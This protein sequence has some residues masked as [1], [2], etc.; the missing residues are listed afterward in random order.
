MT[1]RDMNANSTS[2]ANAATATTRRPMW[3]RILKVSA[4]TLMAIVLYAFGM[5]AA[6]LGLL[7]PERLTPLLEH[8]A[9]NTLRADVTLGHAQ[10]SIRGSFP[11]LGIEM[12]D[13]TVVSRDIKT[14][15]AADREMLPEWADTL[16]TVKSFEGSIKL[17][18]LL[19]GDI[20]IDSVIIDRPQANIVIVDDETNNYDIFPPSEEEDT[21]A[22]NIADLPKITLT[23][24][25]LTNPGPVRF[26]SDG[27]MA[28]ASFSAISLSGKD[29]PLYR[30]DF[31][32]DIDCP[33]ISEIFGIED[34]GFG[35]NGNIRWD[36]AKPEEIALEGFAFKMSLIQGNIDTGVNIGDSARINDLRLH[37]DPL[38]VGELLAAV[39]ED[40]AEFYGIPVGI[41]T[42]ARISIDAKLLK[43]FSLGAD[44]DALPTMD[45]DVFVADSYLKWQQVDFRHLSADMS[46]H[47]DGNDLNASVLTIRQLNI[48]GPATNLHLTGIVTEMLGDPLFDGKVNGVSH[49]GALPPQLKRLLGGASISGD[50]TANAR[51][52]GRPS[53]LS[54]GGFQRLLV[55]GDIG[56]RK[57]RWESDTVNYIY[58]DRALFRFGTQETFRRA[59]VTST[60]LLTAN[61]TADSVYMSTPEARMHLTAL[62]MGIGTRNSH[63]H[64]CDHD[65]QP[66]GGGLSF[67]RY[68]MFSVADSSRV[69]LR[70]VKGYA[71]AKAYEGDEHRPHL[72]FDLEMKRFSAGDRSTRAVLR[73]AKTH[74][75]AILRPETDR[76]R[77]IRAIGDS[78]HRADPTLD[79]DSVYEMASAEYRRRRGRPRRAAAKED[80]G[81]EAID[82]GTTTAMRR[83]L[84][85]WDI[86]GTIAGKRAR[87]YTPYFP[88]RNNL[89]DIDIAF[90]NDSLNINHIR[91]IV[92][93]S[94]F[95]I[96][97][98]V[99]NIKKALT[100]RRKK[101]PLGIHLDVSSDTIDVNQLAQAI[102]T[103]AAYS[104][105]AAAGN[106]IN[107]GDSDN[108]IDLDCAIQQQVATE[109]DT[110]VPIL[111]PTNIDAN[112]HIDADNVRYADLM[113]H[114]LHGHA[115]IYNGALNLHELNATSDVGDINLSALYMG[116]RVDELS[117]GFGMQLSRFN[118]SNF[119]SLVPA[120]DSIMPVLRNFSG[121]IDAEIAATTPISPSMDFVLPDFKAAVKLDGKQLV[122]IDPDTFKMLSKWLF[123]KNKKRNIID[124]M[125]I[126]MMV[127]NNQL[128]IFP[129]IFDIDRYRLGIQGYNDFALNF[130]YHVAV[131]KSPLPF[132]FG[133]NIS[134]NPDKMKIRL[135]RARLKPDDALAVNLVDTTRI[136]LLRQISNVFRRGIREGD[137]ARLRLG[138]LHN[139]G[140]SPADEI[141]ANDTLSAADSAAFIREGLIEAPEPVATPESNKSK[142]T[143]NK[144]NK[145]DK[146][147]KRNNP[148]ARDIKDDEK[149]EEEKI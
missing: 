69:R 4:W 112:I 40:M 104:S 62:K 93:S 25:A 63:S 123:F 41:N 24:F 14:L 35:L 56:L 78:I 101:Q 149:S 65:I 131:L 140:A 121:I 76:T 81:T 91:Y 102:F 44:G 1:F 84:R 26:Y 48:A 99:S 88:L 79:R 144:K 142:V 16:L 55:K 110:V 10:L 135:G 47:L 115:M 13:L 120:I 127:E 8:V 37:L 138:S 31:D 60:G 145:S 124:Q 95:T 9:N 86:S 49:L 132:K 80:E 146:R 27:A 103:G 42:N 22:F 23:R 128:Q 20:T 38:P 11:Y 89:R 136:N 114:G 90:N 29:K 82:F 53:M 141:P 75:E 87:L 77:A 125:S 12:R 28:T 98:K 59:G 130:K 72:V 73:G 94:D 68:E 43:P 111:V 3:R 2:T 21:T 134:G 6:V 52:K 32:G 36:Q 74:I 15:D 143:K 137:R 70:D 147:G 7:H 113:L 39:P 30:I 85:S 129:F 108:E 139:H 122:L 133:I 97:G 51:I 54:P 66:M 67:A 96:T 148:A 119:L 126:Q 46:L 109:P 118:L 107:L 19:V 45:V 17:T 57:F 100:S 117:F 33:P 61:L 34:L 106:S 5:V 50:L 64:H 18:D 71:I 116:R 83:V 92:G 58:V 105:A